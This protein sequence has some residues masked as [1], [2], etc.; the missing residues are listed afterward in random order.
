M[1]LDPLHITPII[2]MNASPLPIQ[3]IQSIQS[4]QSIE[5]EAEY[6]ASRD[7]AV[8]LA[9]QNAEKREARRAPSVSSSSSTTTTA[10]SPSATS[11]GVVGIALVDSDTDD[12]FHISS[13]RGSIAEKAKRLMNMDVELGKLAAELKLEKPKQR[14]AKL[15]LESL[16]TVIKRA[17]DA[18]IRLTEEYA[19]EFDGAPG[20]KRARSEE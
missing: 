16:D 18:V 20:A 3:P 6:I 19:R 12:D 7:K 2:Q 17:E 5:S 1:T 9:K 14:A 4:T 8:A 15:S 10:P 11:N 13:T